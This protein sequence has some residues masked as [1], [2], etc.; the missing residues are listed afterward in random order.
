MKKTFTVNL[1]GRVFQIDEDAYQLLDNY[2]NNL[3]LHF[4]HE[5]GGEEIVR[6][7]ESRISELFSERLHAGK[8]VITIEDTEEIILQMGKPEEII[9]EEETTQTERK[10][11]GT[12]INAIR[13][14]LFRDPEDKMIGGV[15][16][17]LAAFTGWD[18]TAIRL[19]TIVLAFGL[20]GSI[21]FIYLV[22]WVIIPLARTTADKLAMRGLE[23]NVENIG[24]TV[25]DEVN[26]E[27]QKENCKKEQSPIERGVKG[28]IQ[29]IVVVFKILM[30][31]VLLCCTPFIF[32]ALV[33]CFALLMAGTGVAMAVP[34]FM[35][36]HFPYLSD[37]MLCT[38]PA[39]TVLLA[40]TGIIVVLLPLFG[41]IHAAMHQWGK[42]NAFST[43]TKAILLI[44]WFVSLCLW[45]Y[46][47]H[48]YFTLDADGGI[49]PFLPMF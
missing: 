14:K 43:A 20:M 18:V 8:E 27:Q 22:C 2:L 7:M 23:A 10:D 33:I 9:D 21:F 45:V 16:S 26:R 29:F 3:K 1:G 4:K 5:E 19:L 34:R 37:D 28:I 31:I 35:M 32:A 44:L 13:K 36:Y 39:N 38:S 30:V 6:D 15:C 49:Q 40:V 17:G 41:L 25:T 48:H 12:R 42:A 46:G 24:R 47:I 11:E